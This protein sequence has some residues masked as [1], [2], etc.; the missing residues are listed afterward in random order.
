MPGRS[1]HRRLIWRG[2][3]LTQKPPPAWRDGGRGG[4]VAAGYRSPTACGR[5]PLA[6]EG[7]LGI[8]RFFMLFSVFYLS[9]FLSVGL[10]SARRAVPDGSAA[11]MRAAGCGSVVSLLAVLPALLR[12][13]WLTLPPP[14]C[15]SG[16]GGH[17]GSAFVTAARGCA[18]W[19]GPRR[20][21]PV[22]LPAAGSAYHAISAAHPRSASGGRCVPH[23]PELLRRYADAPRVH[24]IYRAER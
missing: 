13:Y 16:R 1:I 12:W 17:R 22:G 24:Q 18:A 14:R 8:V 9:L 3:K 10:L 19:R 7:A 23:G 5:S 6:S 4:G 21:G 20:R 2:C 11:V 15:G